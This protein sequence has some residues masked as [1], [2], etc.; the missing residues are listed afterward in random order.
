MWPT[1]GGVGRPAGDDDPTTEE[2]GPLVDPEAERV[3]PAGEFVVDGEGEGEGEGE[4]L[5]EWGLG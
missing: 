2:D 4:G 1:G 3:E 5:E